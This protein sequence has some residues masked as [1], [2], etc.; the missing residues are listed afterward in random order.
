MIGIIGIIVSNFGF[1][2]KSSFNTIDVINKQWA[3]FLCTLLVIFY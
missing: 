3:L 2:D 1:V